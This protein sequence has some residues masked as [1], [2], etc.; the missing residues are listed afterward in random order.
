LKKERVLF[1]QGISADGN[2]FI[3]VENNMLAISAVYIF[4]C[5]CNFGMFSRNI[6]A[7][8][9]VDCIVFAYS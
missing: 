8:Y 4:I 9:D 1:F 6:T 5:S 2:Y 3:K 7:N